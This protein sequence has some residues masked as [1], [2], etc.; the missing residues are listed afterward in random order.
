MKF[1]NYLLLF[2]VFSLVLLGC[3]KSKER[4]S[5]DDEVHEWTSEH[6]KALGELNR[7]ELATLP[8]IY[9]RAAF[10]SFSPEKKC[11]IWQEKIDLVLTEEWNND[12]FIVITELKKKLKPELYYSENLES[13]RVY[14]NKWADRAYKIGMDSLTVI[15]NFA[16]IATLEEIELLIN[17]PESIDYSWLEDGSG[18]K[19]PDPPPPIYG[20]DCDCEWDIS[21]SLISMGSCDNSMCDETT[22]GCGYGWSS[23]CENV[24]TDDL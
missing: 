2:F 16:H 20:N 12:E 21:C 3:N 18:L 23:P 9:Q 15:V 22:T 8:L 11:K 7:A 1:L 17:S 5:C 24:C 4:F 10:R 19:V 13:T 14:F 6:I